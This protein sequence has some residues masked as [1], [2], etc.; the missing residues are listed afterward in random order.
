MDGKS[1][2]VPE[3]KREL[4][5]RPIGSDITEEGLKSLDSKHMLITVGDVVSLVVREQGIEPDVSIY[6]GMTERR[7]MTEFA[8]LVKR[9][10]WKETAVKN[11]A[12]TITA[13]LVRAV[14][15]AAEGRTK[16]I[17]VEGEEDLAVLPCVLHAPLGTYI[18]YGWPGSGMKLITTDENIRR[19]IQLLIDNMEELE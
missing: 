6:D 13:E 7:E 17:R 19:E 3:N 10:G 18:I 5:K 2:R 8:S 15:K 1:R 11:K 16:I 12:G 14:R 4:F 9:E